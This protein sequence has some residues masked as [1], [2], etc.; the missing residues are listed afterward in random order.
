MA[1]RNKGP[2][3]FF[4]K[5]GGE[6]PFPPE[7]IAAMNRREERQPVPNEEGPEA[8]SDT[9][10]E[11]K[12]ETDRTG[13]RVRTTIKKDA[14]SITLLSVN[15]N[16]E[17]QPV[18]ITRTL[19]PTG[20][21]PDAPTATKSVAIQDLGNGWSIQESSVEG[22]YISGV[23][24]P[25]VFDGKSYEIQRERLI[26][27]K[28]KSSAPQSTVETISAGTSVTAP[29]LG[30]GETARTE[31]R[32]TSTKKSSS[33]TTINVAALPI[34]LTGLKIDDNGVT[35][36]V[37]ETLAEGT[38]TLTPSA[39]VSGDIEQ[40]GDGLSVK[41]QITK[42][43]V[44]DEQT[45]SAE[46]PD[47]VPQKFRGSVPATTTEVVSSATGVTAPA[48]A[49]G[50]LSRTEKRR[51][52]F[53]KLSSVTA[54]SVT[55]FPVTLTGQAIDND[56]VSVTVTE[57]LASGSQSITPSATVGGRV[58]SLGDGLTVKTEESK[59]AVFDASATTYNQ[60][61][62]FP[63]KFIRT[64]KDI[65]VEHTIIST[66][67]SPDDVGNDGFAAIESSARRLTN[68]TV[69][70]SKRTRDITIDTTVTGS[71]RRAEYRDAIGNVTE[72]YGS[73]LT[74]D[75]GALVMSS[76]VEA[77]GGGKQIKKTVQL[78]SFPT[79]QTFY[80]KRNIGIP[81]RVYQIQPIL[82]CSGS[83]FKV[84]INYHMDSATTKLCSTRTTIEYNS[85]GYSTVST[86]GSPTTK[87]LRYDGYF[88]QISLN[89]VLCDS[90][91]WSQVISKTES[92]GSCSILEQLAFT[93]TENGGA[94][95]YG[96]QWYMLSQEAE[97]W[98]LSGF[99]VVTV[100]FSPT[101]TNTAPPSYY[102]L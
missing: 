18:Q 74:A 48:L 54:R 63:A 88:I 58:E 100:E 70:K 29:T 76:D 50:E 38:Q 35:E 26:P 16:N 85:T 39:T 49:T 9:I 2:K 78:T 24:T 10:V 34:T 96:G 66:D 94:S 62:N 37:A 14:G 82:A 17:G 45:Y 84:L 102:V 73:G 64:G 44:F 46:K 57:T 13:E 6:L 99:K 32:V 89:N 42:A 72:T 77:I 101:A 87:D 7:F 31:K 90:I 60:V 91:N 33:V 56:G 69:R 51:T 43:E 61:V 67:A 8:L 75:G 59:S 79:K 22:V 12:V 19:F 80:G 83:L 20:S 92:G 52:K 53:T 71:E 30:T 93:A 47:L 55:S 97:P 86:P 98:G 28:F 1:T 4:S 25:Q 36:S 5:F 41:T 21:T 15:T 95:G 40:L 27:A 11:S 68:F 23:F 81:A 3:L 65:V